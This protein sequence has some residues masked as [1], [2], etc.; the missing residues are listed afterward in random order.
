M[1]KPIRPPLMPREERLRLLNAPLPQVRVYEH[2]RAWGGVHI[3]ETI[4]TE[5]RRVWQTNSEDEEWCRNK[6]EEK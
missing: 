6:W 1:K 4:P 5:G 2:S 3:R